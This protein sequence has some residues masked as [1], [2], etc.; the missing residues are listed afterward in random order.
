MATRF[1]PLRIKP[2]RKIPLP[3]VLIVPFVLL[4]TGSVGLVGYLSFRSGQQSIDDLANRLL[5]EVSYRVSDRLTTYLEIPQ[6][7]VTANRLAVEADHLD[8]DSMEHLR[9]HLWQQFQVNPSLFGTIFA[10]ERWTIGY[11]R[12]ID[13]QQQIN[14]AQTNKL[15]LPF[16]TPLLIR[17]EAKQPQKRNYYLVD[18]SGH[19]T[20]LL[21]S[22]PL[23]TLNLAWYSTAKALTYQ[24]WTQIFVGQDNSTLGM[25]A[26]SPVHN[27][28]GEYKGMFVASL[29]LL[30]INNFL[31]YLDFSPGGDIFI[32]ERSGNLVATSTSELPYL[33]PAGL[34]PQRLVAQQSRDQRTRD[35]SRQLL[36]RFGTF[37]AIQSAATLRL[38][39]N[40]QDQ[41]VRVKPFRDRYGLD[42]LVVVTVPAADFIGQIEANTYT[43]IALSGLTLTIAIA[44]G[45]LTARLINRPIRRLS[46]ASQALAA[47]R[48]QKPLAEDS[49]IA[50]LANLSQAFNHTAEQL[51]QSFERIKT[52]LQE[53]EEKFTRVF[54]YSPDPI[55]ISTLDGTYLNINNSFLKFSGYSQAEVIG[56]T[57]LELNISADLEQDAKLSE[58]L[59]VRG[60]V[61]GFEYRYR[62]KSG[63]IGT[64]LISLELID[65]EGQ[66]CVLS[67]AKEISDR[68]ILEQ[69][70][71]T[72]K[73]RLELVLES[74]Y[75]AIGTARVTRDRQWQFDYLSSGHERLLGF[76]IDEL[77]ADQMVWF[78]RIHPEDLQHNIMPQ[79]EKIVRCQPANYEYRFLHKEGDW[80][81]I[82]ATLSSTWNAEENYWLVTS[83]AADVSDRKRAEE[84]LQAALTE[85]VT[86]LQEVHHRVKNNLQVICSLLRLQKN[87]T[88]DQDII[89]V[90]EDSNNRILSMAL[91]H[92][93]LYESNNFAQVNLAAYVHDLMQSLIQGYGSQRVQTQ[94]DIPPDTA[95]SLE[96]AV[97]C[98][99]IL[100]ELI[101]NAFKHGF[102]DP[103]RG[104]KIEVALA[105]EGRSY[106]L[107]VANNGKPLPANFSLFQ[108]R[109]SL[110]IQLMLVLT[111]QLGG[112]LKVESG[113]Q[114]IFQLQ[115]NPSLQLK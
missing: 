54:R 86:L 3:W 27:T 25:L 52:A 26:V 46:L 76:T 41:L 40:G 97:P 93:N 78:S 102:A 13:S 109:R 74:S 61:D 92:Q 30:Q 80:R 72:S 106:V 2:S 89:T 108:A 1:L 79:F 11:I 99:L 49:P 87:R 21:V 98:G 51:Q 68:K 43:T 58:L 42:W 110:G 6:Q 16:G 48:W 107:S 63:Q 23:S 12:T 37:E 36:Q 22:T 113:E 77:K 14:L 29:P 57:P 59:M 84:Q 19:P 90:L 65:L 83:V 112:K 82:A 94:I 24:A 20:R 56:R 45:L 4:V 64:A 73:D 53:S 50:E 69:E 28:K 100:N 7:A 44:L 8:F 10:T 55:S 88:H 85:K 75:A 9:E 115:F 62:T 31:Q 33:T 114:T 71:Q 103:D 91:V 15:Q 34:P 81:W 104:G 105:I 95:V 101:T 17:I 96:Q 60:R 70:L 111:E 67:I 38:S 18:D 66:S 32:I 47:G 39:S 5:N 35:I